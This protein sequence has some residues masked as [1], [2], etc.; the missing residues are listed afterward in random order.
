MA[1]FGERK[2]VNG[3]KWRM[4][5]EDVTG[6]GFEGMMHMKDVQK[7]T[8][9]DK[10]HHLNASTVQTHINSTKKT[11]G[12]IMMD[13]IWDELQKNLERY[14]DTLLK[15]ED[16]VEARMVVAEKW[17]EVLEGRRNVEQA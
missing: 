13:G 6:D 16:L 15:Y 5:T 7:M 10:L 4:P 12:G 9:V 1:D 14:D 11:I 17:M 8:K 2:N 3:M